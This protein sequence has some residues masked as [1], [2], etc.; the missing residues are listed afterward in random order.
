MAIFFPP[1]HSLLD[2]VIVSYLSYVLGD[3]AAHHHAFVVDEQVGLGLGGTVEGH[4]LE[5]QLVV[6]YT[7]HLLG[8]W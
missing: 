5:A 3:Q 8:L 1:L 2:S 4:L 6:C 7:P